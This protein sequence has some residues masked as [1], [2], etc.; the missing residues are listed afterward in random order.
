MYRFILMVVT[1]FFFLFFLVV[2]LTELDL[3]SSVLS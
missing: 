3:A 1:F 2:E